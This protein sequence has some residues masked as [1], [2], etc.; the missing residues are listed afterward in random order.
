MSGDRRVQRAAR[1]CGAKPIDSTAWYTELRRQTA[2]A[3]DTKPIGSVGGTK[4]WVD[5]FSDPEILRQIEQEAAAAPPPKPLPKSQPESSDSGAD[6]SKSESESR[7][8][9]RRH[10]EGPLSEKGE[11]G[12]GIFDPF[13]PGYA[14]DLLDDSSDDS[15]PQIQS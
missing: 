5:E 10:R 11:F 9:K 14:E 2:Q 6:K 15:D 13:P 4:H 1:S 8:K 7:K 12:A 3:P